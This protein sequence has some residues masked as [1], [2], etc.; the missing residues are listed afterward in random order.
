MP[1]ENEIVSRHFQG[2]WIPRDIWL[3]RNLSSNAKSLWAEIN[4]L[5]SEE[6]GGCYASN[7]YLC[8]FLGVKQSRLTEI[9]KELRDEGLLIDVSFNGRKR[10]I[11]AIDPKEVDGGRLPTGK[12]VGSMPENRQ[13]PC[14]KSGSLSYIERKEEIKGKE[15][16]ATLSPQK[17]EVSEKVLRGKHVLLSEVEY[18]ELCERFEKP[19][20]DEYIERIDDYCSSKGE[21]YKDYAA[22]IRNWI[23]RDASK[24][25]NFKSS[26][27][28]NETTQQRIKREQSEEYKKAVPG[29]NNIIRFE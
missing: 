4:S 26:R 12:A 7:E 6:E 18:V 22:T 24:T 8:N 25:S 9:M 21:K 10:I 19:I 17:N 27:T 15:K 29:F 3:N 13:A 16:R 2:I 1:E 23:K 5:F 28:Q 20:V 14:R 11:K